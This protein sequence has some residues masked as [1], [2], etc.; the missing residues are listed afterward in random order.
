M[1]WNEYLFYLSSRW[2]RRWAG[3]EPAGEEEAAGREK[4]PWPQWWFGVLPLSFKLMFSRLRQ[5]R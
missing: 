3:T 5:S 1:S 4:E 2:M